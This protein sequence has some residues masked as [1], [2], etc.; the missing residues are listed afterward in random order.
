[1]IFRCDVKEFIKKVLRFWFSCVKKSPRIY[2]F[3]LVIYHR[4]PDEFKSK[5]RRVLKPHTPASIVR[6]EK[7]DCEF[8]GPKAKVVY[9]L[10][11]NRG[12]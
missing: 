7:E 11:K 12:I 4:C 6:I 8:L 1:M 9:E 5:L 3:L 10:L 2:T